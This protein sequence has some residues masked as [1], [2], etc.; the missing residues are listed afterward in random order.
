MDVVVPQ[1]SGRIVDATIVRQPIPLRR[2]LRGARGPVTSR[3]VRLLHLTAED[4]CEGIGE[5]SSVDWLAAAPAPDVAS[6]FRLLVERI[7]RDGLAE[8]D[9]LEWSLEAAA[10]G[11]VRA[12]V[13]TA[14][15]DLEARRRGCSL[16]AVLG[17][18][19]PCLPQSMSALLVDDD[20]A[21]MARAAAWHARR[22]I[23]CFKVKVGGRDLAAEVARVTAVRNSIGDAAGLR[24]DANGAWSL[25]DARRALDAFEPVR[26]AFVEEPLSDAT[27]T[28]QLDLPRRIALDESVRDMKDLRL[29]IARGGFRVLVLKLERVGGPLAALEMAAAAT[30]AGLEVVFTD[31]IEGA[32]G[33][34]ATAHVAAAAYERAGVP[35][36]A[37]GLGGLFLLDEGEDAAGEIPVYGPGLGLEIDAVVGGAPS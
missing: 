17:A 26:A 30:R 29:A 13:Q 7:R 21:A 28:A 20:P 34:A 36:S 37:V 11:A 3:A 1:L 31:S 6:T 27:Q 8:A 16:A 32:V 23:A 19:D 15:L 9:L 14:L 22:G 5:G 12:A 35:P 4:G 2:P 24:L 33:R 25:D 18:A 10:P